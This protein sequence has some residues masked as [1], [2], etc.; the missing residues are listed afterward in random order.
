[1]SLTPTQVSDNASLPSSVAETYIPDQL[2]AGDQKLVTQ[3]ITVKSSAALLR[4][5]VLGKILYGT[6]TVA[7]KSGGN[8]GNG[9]FVI[10]ATNPVLANAQDG[11]YTLRNLEAVANGGEFELKD[12]KGRSLGRYIIV[13][14]AG[15]T[16]AIADQIKGVLTDG[17]TDFIVGDGFDIT[18]AA[19]TGKY[20][21]AVKT[22]VDGSAIPAA[23]LADNADASGGDVN[24]GAYFTG[25]FNGN[26][27]IYDASF[28]TLAEITALLRDKNIHVKSFISNSDP[29]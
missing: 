15:G 21:K 28:T 17:G 19:G 27:L 3:P 9:T 24:S 2:I 1:M 16:I 29:T 10:D 18:V 14:G 6:A 25:E 8:T 12:P 20:V 22:A 11:V 4:G 26:R 5:T 13:A 23:I 7:A